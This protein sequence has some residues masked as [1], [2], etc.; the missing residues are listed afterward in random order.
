MIKELTY[1]EALKSICDKC[2]MEAGKRQ[3]SCPFRSIDNDYCKEYE[4]VKEAIEKAKK[5]DL[6]AKEEN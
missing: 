5:Y 4:I 3:V 1:E 6:L 2:Y